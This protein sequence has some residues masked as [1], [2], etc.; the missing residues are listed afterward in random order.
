MIFFGEDRKLSCSLRGVPKLLHTTV[1]TDLA[2][3]I[4]P[5]SQEGYK[6]AISFTDDISGVIAVYFLKNKSDNNISDREVLDRN[7]AI[8]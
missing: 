5:P 8:R 6:Y 4:E 2:G 3:P 7:C 1:Y